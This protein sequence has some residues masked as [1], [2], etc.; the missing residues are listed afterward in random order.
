MDYENV[1]YCLV[2]FWICKDKFVLQ[3]NVVK[4]VFGFVGVFVCYIVVIEMVDFVL[5]NEVVLIQGN[6][7]GNLDCGDVFNVLIIW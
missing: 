1:G 7:V 6:R 2:F 4:D 5:L 3:E